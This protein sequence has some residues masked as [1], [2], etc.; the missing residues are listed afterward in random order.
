MTVAENLVLARAALPP[1]STGRRR[2]AQLGIPRPMP[3]RVPLDATVS[4]LS[5]GEKQKIEILKQLYLERRFLILDE[6]TSVLTPQEAD[7]VLGLLRQ[8]SA[9]SEL[10]VL[11]ITHKFR[12]VM[13]FADEVTVLRRG[14]LAGKGRVEATH[15]RRHGRHDDRRPGARRS[16]PRARGRVRR[17]A[18]RDQAALARTMTPAR[19]RCMSC[20]SQVKAGEIVGIAGVSGNGQRQLVEVSG[21]P[22]RGERRRDPR[23]T[24]S[25]TRHARGDAP[26]QALL[27]AGGAAAATPASDA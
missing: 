18:A 10:T 1:S 11:M 26:A 12:E 3:F 7:E 20:R 23:C 25:P 22:T 6:P 24:A 5:A 21:R 13:A 19:R 17:A 4:A 15:L 2:R 9:R 27:P 16:S 14:Q 8:M